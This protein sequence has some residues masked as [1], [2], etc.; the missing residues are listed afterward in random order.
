MSHGA[1][2]QNISLIA[3]TP[4][5][6]IPE[7][8][9]FLPIRTSSA[10]HLWVSWSFTFTNIISNIIDYFIVDIYLQ[11]YFTMIKIFIFQNILWIRFRFSNYDWFDSLIFLIDFEYHSLRLII[12]PGLNILQG[13]SSGKCSRF[14]HESPNHCF[15]I[16]IYQL[17]NYIKD[18]QNCSETTDMIRGIVPLWGLFFLLRLWG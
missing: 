10:Q 2:G 3:P 16:R 7:P 14:I 11:F 9:E 8:F 17:L 15:H 12:L 13:V 18:K 1:H 6:L 4:G 5:Y